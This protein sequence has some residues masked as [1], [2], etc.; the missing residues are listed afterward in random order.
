MIE[1]LQQEAEPIIDR[2]CYEFGIKREEVI[3]DTRR[4]RVSTPRKL[5]MVILRRQGWQLTEIGKFLNNR[6]HSTVI[7]GIKDIE[8]RLHESV[9][10]QNSLE[11]I[12]LGALACE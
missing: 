1:Q 12:T 3:G 11:R 8:K 4:H 6:H 2:L 7:Y 10:M 9:A 5:L